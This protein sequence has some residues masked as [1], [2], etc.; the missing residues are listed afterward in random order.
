MFSTPSKELQHKTYNFVYL[1]T[2]LIF[3]YKSSAPVVIAHQQIENDERTMQSDLHFSNRT[4]L[5]GY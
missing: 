3:S 5:Y 1:K 2:Y 4:Q